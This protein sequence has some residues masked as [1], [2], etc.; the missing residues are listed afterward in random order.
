MTELTFTLKLPPDNFPIEINQYQNGYVII[1]GYTFVFYAVNLQDNLAIDG[2]YIV[3]LKLLL[4]K[5][6]DVSEL[7]QI[8]FSEIMRYAVSN[9]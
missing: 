1:G 6:M 3:T 9:D 5:K 7:N 8:L 4:K 2:C